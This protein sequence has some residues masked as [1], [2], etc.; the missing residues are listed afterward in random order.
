MEYHMRF[1][2]KSVIVAVILAGGLISC[3]KK[4]KEAV[5]ADFDCITV[6]RDVPLTDATDAPRCRI[7]MELQTAKGNSEKSKSINSIIGERLFG[8]ENLSLSQAADSFANAYV[9]NY[10]EV[11]R[12]LYDKDK[13]D[14]TR[15]SWYEYHYTV[16][17][18][19]GEGRDGVIVYTMKSD[20]YEGGA[21]G[22]TQKHVVNFDM[23]TGRRLALADILVPGYEP[24]L[25]EM[26]LKALE[27]KVG[28]KNMTEL[29]DKGYLYSMDMFTPENFIIGEDNITFIY[30]VYEIAPFAEGMTELS[31]D[32]SEL[33]DLLP[34]Q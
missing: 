20:W 31:I 18:E 10:M 22:L 9:R 33:N 14:E 29:H 6:S 25:N 21:H 32:Y 1:I 11:L 16:T 24:R 34:K 3:A 17:T 27:K 5:R 12:P 28:A 7:K 30:N 19:V 13:A 23:K 8:Y 4:T 26:L 15:R 2:S